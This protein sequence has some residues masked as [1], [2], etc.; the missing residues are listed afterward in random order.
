MSMERANCHGIMSI[1]PMRSSM[2]RYGFSTPENYDDAQ[3]W[4]GG[5]GTQYWSNG[6]RCGECGDNWAFTRP[7]PN[8]EG[9]KY[10]T[11]IIAANYTQAQVIDVQV[12]LKANHGGFLEFRLCA[13][14]K[15]VNE[16]TTDECF[17]KNLLQLEDGSTRYIIGMPAPATTI[18]LKV[19]L[20]IDVSCQYCVLQMWW[21]TNSNNNLGCNSTDIGC[22]NQEQYKNC[23]DVT[24]APNGGMTTTTYPTTTYPTSTKTPFPPNPC[25]R[26]TCTDTPTTTTTTTSTPTSPFACPPINGFY[27][28]P[29]NCNAYYQCVG[30]SAVSSG[31][32]PAPGY[33]DSVTSYCILPSFG[34]GCGSR[35]YICPSDGYYQIPGTT[36][37]S[38]FYF[39]F[40]NVV[41]ETLCPGGS[42]YNPENGHCEAAS[43]IPGC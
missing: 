7:R 8:D 39:C 4:C 32:C 18:N 13:D 33:F 31:I 19:R 20:P 34:G 43:N 35:P 23:A 28:D 2:W 42:F 24:I 9:G 16:L 21:K 11:G 38:K 29:N 26:T 37:S 36:C 14:K 17:D 3:L 30:G 10:G 41:Y 15:N 22:G 27:P 25:L 5:Y 1:P 40:N 12:I 6:G